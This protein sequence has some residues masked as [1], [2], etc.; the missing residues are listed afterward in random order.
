V[1]LK[2]SIFRIVNFNGMSFTK[3]SKLGT[4]P[5]LHKISRYMC[6]C[7]LFKFMTELLKKI[8]LVYCIIFFCHLT[9]TAI[10][11]RLNQMHTGLRNTAGSMKG[12]TKRGGIEKLSVRGN[13]VVLKLR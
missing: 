4:W 11:H 8:L 12:Y 10:L 5:C 13:A 7:L 6:G 3:P 9:A 2:L 1:Q